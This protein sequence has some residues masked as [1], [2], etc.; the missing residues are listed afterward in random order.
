L[1][2]DVCS[3]IRKDAPEASFYLRQIKGKIPAVCFVTIAE[4]YKWAYQR[5]WSPKKVEELD[6]WLG[7]FLIL[8]CEPAVARQ[9]ARIQTAIPGRTFPANDAWVAASAITFGCPLLTHNR[10]DFQ[11]IPG[12]TVI[13]HG[14]E[15]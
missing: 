11:D 8:P 5:H 2:T 10:K 6:E 1:D 15:Q 3:F 12:L 9:W 7:K 14:P 13:S 4:L